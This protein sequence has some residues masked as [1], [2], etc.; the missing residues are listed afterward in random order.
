MAMLHYVTRLATTLATAARCDLQGRDAG[1]EPL[2]DARV[3]EV[4]RANS[5]TG[6]SPSA[7]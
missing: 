3:P 5:P 6:S 7:D 2:G 1:A 4:V